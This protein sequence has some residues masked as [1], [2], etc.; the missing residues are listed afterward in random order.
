MELG[1][2]TNSYYMEKNFLQNRLFALK[3]A[4]LFF[5]FFL[6]GQLDIFEGFVLSSQ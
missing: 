5:F 1:L 4:F 2:K 6:G 3:S